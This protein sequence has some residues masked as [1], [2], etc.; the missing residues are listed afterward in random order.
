M[1]IKLTI[2]PIFIFDQETLAEIRQGAGKYF[3]FYQ[4]IPFSSIKNYFHAGTI[5]QMI[6]N[7][8]LLSPLVLF[9]EIFLNQRPKAWKVALAASTVSFTIE[10]AQLFINLSTGHP[11]RVADVDDIILNTAGVILTIILTRYIGKR[12]NIQEKLQKIF[13]R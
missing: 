1:V 9:I 4:I 12:S 10:I 11:S 3:I 8:I 5:I 13:Y 7:I 2:F 6:G